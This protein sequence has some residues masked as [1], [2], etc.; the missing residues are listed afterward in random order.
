MSKLK[1][2]QMDSS[3]FKK[4]V[5]DKLLELSDEKMQKDINRRDVDVQNG[6]R[7]NRVC[8]LFYTKGGADA[9]LQKGNFPANAKQK[10]FMKFLKAGD[11]SLDAVQS[12]AS[13][14]GL[15]L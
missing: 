7:A 8:D 11:F 5:V 12:A 1:E 3:R 9:V 2:F 10:T 6:M 4:A 13:A 14:L 15:T